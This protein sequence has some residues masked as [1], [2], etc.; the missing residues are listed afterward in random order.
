MIDAD[1]VLTVLGSGA[2]TVVDASGLRFTDSHAV[3]RGQPV[4]MLG[5][6]VDFLTTGCRYDIKRRAGLAPGQLPPNVRR[7]RPPR[8]SKWGASTDE[9]PRHPRLPRPQPLRP[10]QG[11]P[12]ARRPR[13]AGGLSD[14]PAPRL[15]GRAAGGDPDPAR[16]HLLLRRAGRLRAPHDRGR[17][18]LARARA[19]A[20]RPR[21]PVPRRH[22]GQLRQDAQPRPAARPVPRHLQLRGGGGGAGGRRGGPAAH[23]PPAAARARGPSARAVRLPGRARGSRPPRPAP[24]L[25]PLDR[26]PGARRRGAGHALDPPER[27]LAGAARPR[28]VPAPHPGDR[29]QRDPP[30]RGRDRLGQAA[31]QPDPLRPRAAGAAAGAGAR[32]P[33]TPS[34][35]PSG[36]ASRWSSSRST[37]TTAR[38]C[39][40]TSPP[41]SRCGRRSR[42]R[43]STPRW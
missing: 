34:R 42:R 37:A 38:G 4:A 15:R 12:P 31:D 27:P 25:R 3:H 10:A 30:H 22:A 29:H 1:G 6:K 11:D 21:A 39:R 35:P 19:G 40:S 33:R 7:D 18:D 28:Q 2:V 24:R 17:G 41:R 9:D 43:T 26:R 23:P 14:R 20:R 5:L 36:W 16:A 32:S 8:P 13:R